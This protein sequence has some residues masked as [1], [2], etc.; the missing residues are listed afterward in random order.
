MPAFQD[1]LIELIRSFPGTK[2]DLA[3]L[4]D[5]TPSRLSHLLNAGDIPSMEV[6]LRLADATGTSASK[7]LRVAGKEDVAD[8]IE[9]LYGPAAD[10]RQA[11]KHRISPAESGFL[12]QWRQLDQA[13]RRAMTILIDRLVALK[14]AING[15]GK[16]V[17]V[18][19]RKKSRG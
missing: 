4:L 12:A 15:T 10:H 13:D 11:H 9:R 18:S 19:G 7:V 3:K 8:L 14:A 16:T 2:R 17:E 1:L 5:I 6:C